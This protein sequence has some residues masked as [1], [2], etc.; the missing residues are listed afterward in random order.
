M[1]SAPDESKT[2]ITL[3]RKLSPQK[4]EYAPN[5]YPVEASDS[6]KHS[7][8][9]APT[10]F[11]EA[12]R[13]GS[14]PKKRLFVTVDAEG[15]QVQ[16]EVPPNALS[17]GVN[18]EDSNSYIVNAEDINLDLSSYSYSVV[19]DGI[20]ED[21]DLNDCQYTEETVKAGMK[22]DEG[23]S[24]SAEEQEVNSKSNFYMMIEPEDADPLFK[25]HYR[26]SRIVASVSNFRKSYVLYI[27]IMKN[28]W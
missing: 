25:S 9:G 24:E 8:T 1:S 22:S 12:G 18:P 15:N 4:P 11:V 17:E 19:V 5:S 3:K 7:I 14:P 16:V 6:H 10:D 20:V 27:Y 21:V 2:Y 26:M 28:A 23:D 13:L